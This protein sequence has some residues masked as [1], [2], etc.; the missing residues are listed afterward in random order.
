MSWEV[1]GRQIDVSD[2]ANFKLKRVLGE[3]D[4]PR[5]FTL[6]D[7]V[8]ELAFAHFLDQIDFNFRFAVVPFTEELLTRL[9][10]GSI[11][12]LE[13]LEQPRLWIVDISEVWKPVAAWRSTLG[14]VPS[15]CLPDRD[16]MLWPALEPLISLRA[17]GNKIGEGTTP[18]SVVTDVVNGAKGAIR[19]LVEHIREITAQSG[20][21]ADERRRWYDLPTQ[22]RFASFEVALGKP[23]I[24]QSL[25]SVEETESRDAVYRDVS[26]LLDKGLTWLLKGIQEEPVWKNPEERKA[27]LEAIESLIPSSLG[28]VTSVRIGGSLV[29]ALEDRIG[30]INLNKSVKQAARS[31][32]A[33]K[34]NRD[35]RIVREIG[36]IRELD[37]D[38]FTFELRD[39]PDSWTR[40][41]KFEFDESL[42]DDVNQ[43]VFL[44]E[45]VEVVGVQ[46]SAKKA[47][48]ARIVHP[49]TE[50]EKVPRGGT[51]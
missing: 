22:F 39:K 27:V 40:T 4:G 26:A 24:E 6:E 51:G 2:F 1:T 46:R 34:S 47:I 43:A 14:V 16:V 30:R 25:I 11:S 29:S 33:G 50:E 13:A 21:P 10:N 28:P 38:R 18:A 3:Y 48:I 42:A 37:K 12:I 15:D 5:T 31:A 17:I 41:L 8:G 9:T 49:V 36:Y 35:E 19:I 7:D 20:R 32:L 23:P 45:Y 44:D